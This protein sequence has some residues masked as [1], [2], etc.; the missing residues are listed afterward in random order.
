MTPNY[1]TQVALISV[2]VR[3]GAEVSQGEAKTLLA[4]IDYLENRLET[5]EKILK[6]W[7]ESEGGIDVGSQD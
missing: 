2:R 5:V 3:N 4:W 7:N 6:R 1:K